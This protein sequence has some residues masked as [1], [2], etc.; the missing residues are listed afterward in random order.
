[1][2]LNTIEQAIESRINGAQGKPDN[3]VVHDVE[4]LAKRIVYLVRKEL[5]TPQIEQKT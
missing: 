5:E 3:R 4:A 1:M 2:N